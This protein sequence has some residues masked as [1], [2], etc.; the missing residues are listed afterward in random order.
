MPTSSNYAAYDPPTRNGSSAGGAFGGSG[1][2][3]SKST[4]PAAPLANGG[5]A[6]LSY[7][8]QDVVSDI[9]RLLDDASLSGAEKTEVIST[10]STRLSVR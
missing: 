3:R 10:V 6:P 9:L 1:V 5:G 8:Q 4:A 7:K 2:Y